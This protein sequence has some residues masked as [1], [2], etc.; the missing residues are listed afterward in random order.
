MRSESAL[1]R[2]TAGLAIGIGRSVRVK[3]SYERYDFSDFDDEN[4]IHAGIAGPF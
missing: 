3:L 2:H 4:V 1:I